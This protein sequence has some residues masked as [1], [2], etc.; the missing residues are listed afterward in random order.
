MS[1]WTRFKMWIGYKKLKSF[2]VFMLVDLPEPNKYKNIL[3]FEQTWERPDGTIYITESARFGSGTVWRYLP[4]FQ[5]CGIWGG[6]RALSDHYRRCKA[7]KSRQRKATHEDLVRL[8]VLN[9]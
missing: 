8:G 5:R 4:S 9:G 3:V 1:F 7:D 6:E 2:K